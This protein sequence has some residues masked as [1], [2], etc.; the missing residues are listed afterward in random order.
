MPAPAVQA[1]GGPTPFTPAQDTT[2]TVARPAGA[3]DGDYMLAIFV[4]SL[5]AVAMTVATPAG[6][7]RVLD[8]GAPGQYGQPF[9]FGKRLAEGDGGCTVLLAGGANG[10]VGFALVVRDVDDADPLAD[11]DDAG[12][13]FWDNP[14]TH[15]GLTAPANSLLVGLA[16]T[17]NAQAWTGPAGMTQRAEGF[18]AGPGV[19]FHLATETWAPGGATGPRAWSRSNVLGGVVT[20]LALRPAPDAP[21]P[22]PDAYEPGGGLG[23]LEFGGGGFGATPDDPLR[24]GPYQ[25]YQAALT[26]P[27]LKNPPASAL[28]EGLGAAK[29]EL[30][31]RFADAVRARAIARAGG[32][33]LALAGLERGLAPF[34]GEAPDAYRA[35]LVG[36]FELWALAGTTAGVREVLRL[37]G[38]ASSVV[39]YAGLGGAGPGWAAFDALV[40]PLERAPNPPSDAWSD[41]P[42][43]G[44]AW[45]DDPPE[46]DN[47][48]YTAAGAP[49]FDLYAL[50]EAFTPAD[51]QL[52]AIWLLPGGDAWDG[53]DPGAWS[54]DPPEGDAWAD[55]EPILVLR[56]PGDH[57]GDGSMWDDG[58]TW[59]P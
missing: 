46:G 36:A 29:D 43:G 12:F 16:T 57:W 4:P 55:D 51:R 44:D 56:D 52:G 8:L 26:P 42:P 7:A 11:A 5:R 23:W 58:S 20:M 14:A 30:L 37:A 35:R 59:R 49:V 54:E 10:F 22:P 2:I 17:A 53:D 13:G 3:R 27:W 15:P 34:P 33:A 40:W 32:D 1:V 18:E 6:W 38:W 24:G 39:E 19:S 45:T 9:V 21:P 50:V 28:L 41:D 31:E 25:A 48:E 47:W